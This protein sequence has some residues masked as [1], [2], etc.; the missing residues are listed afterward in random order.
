MSF[1]CCIK[2]LSHFIYFF[3]GILMSRLFLGVFDIQTL[4]QWTSGP[5]LL[6]HVGN[7]IPQ[8]HLSALSFA[9]HY[10]QI[11][12]LPAVPKVSVSEHLP[13]SAVCIWICCLYYKGCCLTHFISWL[14]LGI[15][16]VPSIT[17]CRGSTILSMLLIDPATGRRQPEGKVMVLKILYKA[18]HDGWWRWDHGLCAGA[19]LACTGR[20]DLS[21][22]LSTSQGCPVWLCRRPR[23][24][25]ILGK[26]C[27]YKTD[28]FKIW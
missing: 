1:Y 6:I 10:S 18:R 7:R 12:R 15:A 9:L 3:T 26:S 28:Q 19:S 23:K 5:A 22:P 25:N 4:L 11:K 8:S 27:W 13:A 21:G 17:Y 24:P 16:T 2:F 14:E 20:C